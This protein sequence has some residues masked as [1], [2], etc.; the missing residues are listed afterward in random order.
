M[1]QLNTKQKDDCL[2]TDAE[3]ILLAKVNLFMAEAKKKK[4]KAERAEIM[5]AIGAEHRDLMI[6][7]FMCRIS[8]Q[9]G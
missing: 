1:N 4:S 6:R 8:G 2:F 3:K 5:Q 9:I 7:W